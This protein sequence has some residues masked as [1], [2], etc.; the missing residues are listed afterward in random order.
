VGWGVRFASVVV[1]HFKV[2]AI[3]R[4][5]ECRLFTWS[6]F[7]FF[8]IFNEFSFRSADSVIEF[9]NQTD[10][11]T[12]YP[13][14]IAAWWG[15][16]SV[17]LDGERPDSIKRPWKKKKWSL[18]YTVLHEQ[19]QSL[20]LLFCENVSFLSSGENPGQNLIPF[21]WF[22]LSSLLNGDSLIN[23]VR[24]CLLEMVGCRLFGRSSPGDSE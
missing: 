3:D 17:P 10:W 15:G 24:T 20:F 13:F 22:F 12:D 8:I 6:V 14:A 1:N 16:Q 19:R 18:N 4:H 9:L 23:W 2:K 21:Y 7:S 5:V 11:W